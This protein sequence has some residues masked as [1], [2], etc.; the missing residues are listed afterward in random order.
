MRHILSLR[1]FLGTKNA[2]TALKGYALKKVLV[3]TLLF[4]ILFSVAL[5]S[6]QTARTAGSFRPGSEPDGFRDIKWGTELSSLKEMQLRHTLEGENAIYERINDDM[7][8]GKVRLQ[9]IHYG[10]RNNRLVDVYITADGKQ[11]AVLKK[12]MTGKFGEGYADRDRYY[13]MGDKS[14]VT[15]HQERETGKVRVLF[16]SVPAP[17]NASA[18]QKDIDLRWIPFWITER[19][20]EVYYDSKGIEIQ[21]NSLTRVWIKSLYP[22]RRAKEQE[23]AL[24]REHTALTEFDCPKQTYRIV[25]ESWVM[26]NGQTNKNDKPGPPQ[27]AS[28]H[29]V[30]ERLLQT[31]C[32][33]TAK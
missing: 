7:R 16:T 25:Q 21:P 15:F 24:Y 19:D 14:I 4:Q 29:A 26:R 9:T 5:L 2:L 13:W 33:K 12:M 18:L 31:V 3:V 22:E 20:E 28:S 23:V 8:W 17:K 32:R 11:S 6:A 1:D 10:F 30:M 27:P